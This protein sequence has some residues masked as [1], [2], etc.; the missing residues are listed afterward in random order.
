MH[1][2]LIEILLDD[3]LFNQ[4]DKFDLLSS[5]N[6]LAETKPGVV[7]IGSHATCQQSMGRMYR[8]SI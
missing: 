8:D 5:I 4:A 7:H 3:S 2:Q 1:N 6:K